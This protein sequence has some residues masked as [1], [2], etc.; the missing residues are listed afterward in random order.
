M[1]IS[2]LQATPADLFVVCFVVPSWHLGC[3]LRP[4]HPLCPPRISRSKGCTSSSS[5]PAGCT[6]SS[7][8]PAGCT[9]SSSPAGGTS[10]SSSPAGGASLSSPMR[11]SCTMRRCPAS[12]SGPPVP[13]CAGFKSAGWSWCVISRLWTRHSREPPAPAPFFGWL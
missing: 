6:S 10:S 1:L 13:A 5:P 2:F 11:S 3:P 12:S 7:S 8:P 4:H 9:S